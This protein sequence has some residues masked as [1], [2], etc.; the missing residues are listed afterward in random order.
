VVASSR[1]TT[2]TTGGRPRHGGGRDVDARARHSGLRHG[3][4]LLGPGGPLPVRV[5]GLRRGCRG[6]HRLHRRSRPLVPAHA[7]RGDGTRPALRLDH[8]RHGGTLANI[9]RPALLAPRTR[10]PVSAR[11]RPLQHARSLPGSRTRRR[12][13]RA[14]R[15]DPVRDVLDR[16]SR[17]ARGRARG[18]LRHGPAAAS[19]GQ[20]VGGGCSED[21]A[22]R[23]Q[24]ASAGSGH[25]PDVCGAAHGGGARR[26]QHRA[27][28]ARHR[29][30]PTSRAMERPD[31][32]GLV[33][34]PDV[35]KESWTS[36]A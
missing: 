34:L 20:H 2:M 27:V 8:R 7:C 17:V 33:G 19:P 21:T 31:V 16:G 10:L 1:A 12:A 6:E 28:Q 35:D 13:C 15:S 30:V 29:R 14:A 9:S 22:G 32:H 36:C 25:R 3:A 18:A 23:A 26:R 5:P 11:L 24:V 4:D